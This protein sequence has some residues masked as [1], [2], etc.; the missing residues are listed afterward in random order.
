MLSFRLTKGTSI[1]NPTIGEDAFLQ[2]LS[3]GIQI[4]TGIIFYLITIRLFDQAYVGAIAMYFSIIG[5]FQV[6]FTLGLGNATQHFVSYNIGKREFSAIASLL[7]KIIFLGMFL[8]LIAASLLFV[9]SGY[10]SMLF[11]HSYLYIHQVRLISLVLAGNIL[12][13]VFNGSLLGLQRFRSSAA[14]NIGVW[15]IYYLGAVLLYLLFKSTDW[16]IY[17]WLVGIFFGIALDGVF[18]VKRLLQFPKGRFTSIQ[19]KTIFIYSI[20]V[21]FGAFINFGAAYADR[22]IVASLLD[23]SLLGVYNIAILI[24]LSLELIATPFNNILMPKFSEWYGK[25]DRKKIS[26]VVKLSSLLLSA[27]YIPASI[28]ISALGYL[29]IEFIAGTT[30]LGSY[31]PLGIILFSSSFFIT[32][33]ILGKAVAAVR[34]TKALVVS[35]AASFLIN[36]LLSLI[37]I[38]KFG[39]VGASIGFSSVY[40]LN[41]VVLYLYAKKEDVVAF[42]L[43]GFS[44]VWIASLIMFG[45]LT[46]LIHIF[47]TFLFYLPIYIIV[48]IGLYSFLIKLF[49]LFSREDSIALISLFGEN[50]KI[51]RKIVGFFL[52]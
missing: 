24:A 10:V 16:L 18:I 14:I 43:L 41:F 8:S 45:I 4:L 3:S 42:D 27:A 22:F 49:K 39:L 37:L 36:V 13:A 21:L 6:I 23:L 40:A 52:I 17:G 1:E 20:P 31:M 26:S 30:Y 38:P 44:K 33:N 7:R 19:V 28:G 29:V 35:S 2:Y 48:G 15:I 9:L 5:L 50:G 11:L 46:Y 47:G 32:S 51:L 34:K 25:G 12:Y